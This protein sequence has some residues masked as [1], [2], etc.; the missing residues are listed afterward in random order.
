MAVIFVNS[1]DEIFTVAPG[2]GEE[3]IAAAI[4]IPL[5]L[6]RQSDGAPLI[7]SGNPPAVTV[8]YTDWPD[9]L[10]SDGEDGQEL[11]GC[12]SR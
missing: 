7:S 9:E 12:V 3:G 1:D 8:C 6:V 5:V 11:Y 10:A 2:E 4:A